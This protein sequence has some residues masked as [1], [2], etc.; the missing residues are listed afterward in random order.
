[1]EELCKKYPKLRSIKFVVEAFKDKKNKD[2]TYSAFKKDI[3]SIGLDPEE[4]ETV[5]KW[6][7]DT[8]EH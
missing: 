5:I 3:N 8:M 7:C 6:F 4:Y 1:M 2:A